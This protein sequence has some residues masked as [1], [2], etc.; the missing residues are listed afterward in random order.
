MGEGGEDAC[1]GGGLLEGGSNVG[2][3]PKRVPKKAAHG[4]APNK[5]PLLVVPLKLLKKHKKTQQVGVGERA[6]GSQEDVKE[7]EVQVEESNASVSVAEGGLVEGEE[8]THEI[9]F[10]VGSI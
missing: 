3:V 6:V 2:K 7:E 4:L 1:E 5:K 9:S 10:E 8:K